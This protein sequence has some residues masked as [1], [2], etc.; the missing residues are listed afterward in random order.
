MEQKKP[1]PFRE[2]AFFVCETNQSTRFAV[3]SMPRLIEQWNTLP[4]LCRMKNDCG[5][6]Q[7][8]VSLFCPVGRM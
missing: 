3:R 1:L 8:V 2:A 5:F 7:R 6:M 4:P